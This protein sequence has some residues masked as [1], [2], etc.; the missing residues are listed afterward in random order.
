M[1][2]RLG[3]FAFLAMLALLA[4]PAHADAVI[5]LPS[6]R[7]VTFNDVIWGEPGPAGLTVR[8]RFLEADLGAVVASAAYEDLEADMQYLC[9]NYALA[10]I[11]NTGPQ[12]ATVM[13]SISDR[14]VAFGEAAPGVVQVF[15]AYR[16]EAGQCL[17]E[18]Y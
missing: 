4:P 14:P 10:R 2:A 16:P 7:W 8:F 11:A 17:W 15:E 13:V 18:G 3:R 12:P 5:A 1:G 6:G 9:E